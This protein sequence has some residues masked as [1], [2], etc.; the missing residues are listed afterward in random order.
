VLAPLFTPDFATALGRTVAAGRSATAF[1]IVALGVG[2]IVIIGSAAWSGFRG[3]LVPLTF[4][5][6]ISVTV[7]QT[8]GGLA[9]QTFLDGIT[10]SRYFL[11]GSVCLCILLAW[12]TLTPVRCL[13]L[14]S[15]GFIASLVLSGAAFRTIAGYTHIWLDGPSWTQQI[16]NCPVAEPCRITVWP[17]IG[18]VGDWVVEV[19][20]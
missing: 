18:A 6:W 16:N 12:G 8:F 2:I 1:G 13:K 14:M 3:A 5:S 11:F 20:K 17:A 10:G 4:F 7:I 15:I 19:T 9:P